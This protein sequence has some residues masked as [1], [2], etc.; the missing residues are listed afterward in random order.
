MTSIMHLIYTK[1]ITC[2]D[3]ILFKSSHMVI[4]MVMKK[5]SLALHGGAGTILKNQMNPDLEEQ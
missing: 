3:K 1:A 4:K 5:Y 2:T